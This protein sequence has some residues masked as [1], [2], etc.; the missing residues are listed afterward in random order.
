MNETT[1]ELDPCSTKFIYKCLDVLKG[2]LTKMVKLSLRQD[3][4]TQDWK[5]GI[6]KS[7]IKKTSIWIQN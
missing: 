5:L 4:F 3:L 1:C 7:L 6:T 2:T